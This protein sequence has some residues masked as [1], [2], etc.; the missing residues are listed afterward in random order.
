MRPEARP[1]AIPICPWEVPSTKFSAIP[2]K[3][4]VDDTEKNIWISIPADTEFYPSAAHFEGPQHDHTSNIFRSQ[5]PPRP[6]TREPLI[7]TEPGQ[8][9]HGWALSSEEATAEGPNFS[10]NISVGGLMPV[11]KFAAVF[12][13]HLKILS[14]RYD[15]MVHM[16]HTS[17]LSSCLMV[18]ADASQLWH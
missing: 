16:V 18:A 17:S 7:S 3:F 6:E 13:C 15:V 4:P 2:R 11:A 10:A 14:C 1:W 8:Q 9:S 5:L 12:S